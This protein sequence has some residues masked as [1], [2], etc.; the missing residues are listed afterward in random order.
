MYIVVVACAMALTGDRSLFAFDSV[1]VGTV[2]QGGDFLQACRAATATLPPAKRKREAV[3]RIEVTRHAAV[4][5][6]RCAAAVFDIFEIGKDFVSA[7]YSHSSNCRAAGETC[8]AEGASICNP[9]LMPEIEVKQ[10]PFKDL[11][12]A[13]NV[14]PQIFKP[15]KGT[16]K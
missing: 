9:I 14:R 2:L 11:E 8:G 15:C 16:S 10:V 3:C 13:Q 5:P 4:A 1:S 6:R 12:M 7:T